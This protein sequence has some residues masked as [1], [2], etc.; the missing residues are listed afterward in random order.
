MS[1]FVN[2]LARALAAHEPRP[3][4]DQKQYAVLL[5]LVIEDGCLQILYEVRAQGI[6]QPG[7]TAFP[8]GRI[9][10][11]ECP[12]DAA[13]RETCE[14]LGLSPRDIEV[15]GEL[16]FVVS[17]TTIIYCFVGHIKKKVSDLVRNPDEVAEVFTLSLAWL[18][19]HPPVYYDA[20][21]ETSYNG[22]FPVERLP[23]GK[24]YRW[25]RR[26]HLVGFYDIPSGGYNLWGFTAKMTDR[27]VRFLA[28][29]AENNFCD[30]EEVTD[31]C[32]RAN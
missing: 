16:D 4:G 6:S 18:A 1:P 30:R 28:D 2:H 8:G 12:S 11:G 32:G 7:E 3:L 20:P 29:K 9:E 21:F 25:S 17:D 15:L 24:N 13:I 14:E 31:S 10:A 23:G 27:F 5:P 26:K 22:N 19:A